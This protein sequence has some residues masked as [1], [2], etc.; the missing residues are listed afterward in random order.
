[1][2][3]K[4]KRPCAHPGCPAL[5]DKQFCEAHAKQD[6]RDYAHEAIIDRRAARHQQVPSE[7]TPF[8]GIIKCGICGS[9]YRRKHAAAGSKYEKLVWICATFNTLGKEHCAAQQIPEDILLTKAEEAG[10]LEDLQEVQMPG[11]FALTFICK[12][13]RQ[14]ELACVRRW[15]IARGVYG[16]Q[17]V[18]LL[19]GGFFT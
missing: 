1:M 10:G 6:A 15:P 14:V 17:D 9:G 19:S 18:L 7:T 11:P 16:T 13:G 8:T 3:Y 2:P 5:T 4:P 12:D